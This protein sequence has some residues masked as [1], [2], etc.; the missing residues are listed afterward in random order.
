MP[1]RPARGPR[2]PDLAA[3]GAF[4]GGAGGERSGALAARL[5]ALLAVDG[6]LGV[7]L[8]E[9]TG[10]A[11]ATVNLRAADATVLFNALATAIGGPVRAPGQAP[12]FAAF[13]LS[14]GQIAIGGD[15]QHALVT[16]TDP[17]LNARALRAL[18]DNFLAELA[19]DPAM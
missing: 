12:A 19:R 5:D 9:R 17:G 10:R 13:S 11:L 4:R 16:L 1:S 7:A 15:D 14:A 8:F 3:A 6:V 2:V 18:L